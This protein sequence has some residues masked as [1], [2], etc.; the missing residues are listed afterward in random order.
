HFYPEIID[1]ETGEVLPDGS[2]GELVFTSL[3]KEAMP[4]I[5]YRTRDLTRLLPPTSR[6]MRRIGKIVGRS[7]DMLIIRGVNLFPTQVEE[8]VLQEPG[9]GGQYQLVVT[10]DGH[11]DEL[12]IRCE[13][14]LGAT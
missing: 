11:L 8:L 1:P 10:R 5:R 7:D 12:L 9:L 6:S 3:T 14:A 4:V 2:E 13:L